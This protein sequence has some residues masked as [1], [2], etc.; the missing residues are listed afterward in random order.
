MRRVWKS[1]II[2]VAITALMAACG[3]MDSDDQWAPGGT[4]GKAL[5]SMSARWR[6]DAR[7]APSK[8]TRSEVRS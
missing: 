2:G 7:S 3:G 1:S 5:I 4:G 8:S 6:T